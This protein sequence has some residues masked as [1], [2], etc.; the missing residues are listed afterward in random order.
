MLSFLVPCCIM[1]LVFAL[2]GKYPFG[3]N[4]LLE[5]DAA[6]QYYPFLLLLR[7]TVRSGGSLLYTWRAGLGT[8][9]WAMIA[10]YCLNPWNLIAIALPESAVQCFLSLS[11][12]IRIGL[13]GYCTAVFFRTLSGKQDFS[14]VVFASL[15]GL[16]QWFVW[17]YFQ[18]IWLDAAVLLPLLLAGMI[19]LV[20]DRRCGMFTAVLFCSL[21]CNPYF[22]FI[23][24]MMTFFCWI[25]ALIILKKPLRTLPREAGRFFG[26]ALLSGCMAAAVLLPLAFAVRT[27]GAAGQT[28]P[29][30]LEFPDSFPALLGRLV[31]M[32]Y[33]I[34]HIGL[35]NLSCSMLGVLLFAGYLTAKRIPLRERL[36]V[37]GLLAFLLVSLWYPP[38]NYIWHGL[39]VPNGFIHR[40]AFLVPFVLLTAGW[41]FTATLSEAE[42]EPLRHRLLQL[43]LMLAAGAGICV[44]GA[45]TEAT[46]VI[47]VSVLFML[48]Y[49]ALY[50]WQYLR[51]KQRPLML[52]VLLLGVSAEAFASAQIA[53]DFLPVLYRADDLAAKPETEQAAAEIRAQA[54]GKP[55]RTAS[56][57]GHGFN[58][59][60]FCDLPFGGT[61]YSS[62]IPAAL[63]D[64]LSDLGMY[65]GADLNRYFYYPLPPVSAL[66]TDIRYAVAPDGGDFPPQF[67]A[68]LGDTCAEQ[69]RYDLPFG[70]CIPATL[71]THHGELTLPERQNLLF[72]GIT[73]KDTDI[74]ILLPA[75]ITADCSDY[76][77]T[78]SDSIAVRSGAAARTCVTFSFTADSDDWYIYDI[79]PDAGF[80]AG[81]RSLRVFSEDELLYQETF[82]EDSPYV[83]DGTMCSAGKCKAGQK[84]RI[85]IRIAAETAGTVKVQLARTD[86][87][88]FS[89][90][91]QM[92]AAYSVVEPHAADTVL[93][94]T[95]TA[96][97]ERPLLYLPV[98]YEKGWHA[99]V[100]G[101][102]AE[103]TEAMP[104]ML[105]L[106][107]TPGTHTFR[108]RY[109]PQG[110]AAGCAV[111]IISILL[112]PL[113][114]R[115]KRNPKSPEEK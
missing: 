53:V 7:R 90:C 34:Q 96:S 61:L 55:E 20:R 89:E 39:H 105:G 104:G 63:S 110:I 14:G 109:V 44:C 25:C 73:G 32:T 24:C 97:A 42:S 91:L 70:F 40:F 37:F 92:L 107:L 72:R 115:K 113:L 108:L 99:V 75:G 95:V 49:A 3:E 84:I 100:D 15:Y 57:T 28:M 67:Y 43:I 82:T 93:S 59:E 27:T 33:P 62:L 101:S 19:R 1:L 98:P 103:I 47:L 65:S 94:G 11:V 80:S 74:C 2:N 9:F 13:A 85:E 12:I 76:E 52:G 8:N 36:T 38:L 23:T 21:I 54:A 46:D 30:L 50:V 88:A 56:T 83:N 18:L 78:G 86:E 64:T 48:I 69:F 10:Y 6:A 51:P 111:S 106:R 68:P 81:M 17:N 79:L 35:P 26:Y 77:L 102:K 112:C 41:R 114:L 29:G 22:S 16:S 87:A 58:P 71:E 66:L 31:S 5:S 4:A 45:V 60:L